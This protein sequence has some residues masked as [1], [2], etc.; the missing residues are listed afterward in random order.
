MVFLGP[1]SLEVPDSCQRSVNPNFKTE[2]LAHDRASMPSLL[3][4]S[5]HLASLPLSAS[6][7]SFSTPF[8]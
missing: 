7:A 5:F 6:P 8:L 1:L 2:A 3:A 4:A